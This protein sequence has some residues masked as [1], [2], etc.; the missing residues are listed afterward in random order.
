MLNVWTPG[1]GD[2]AV[3]S[4]PGMAARRWD[5]RRVGVVAAVRLHEPGAQQ[6]CRRRRYQP[7]PRRPRVP[8]RVASRRRVRRLGQRRHARHRRRARVGARQHRPLRRR[9]G[10]RDDLR[11]VRRRQQDH[12]PARHAVCAGTVPQRVRDEW[13]DARRADPRSGTGDERPH[14]RTPRGRH[15]RRDIAQ[16]RRRSV[17]AGIARSLRWGRRPLRRRSHHQSQ[18]SSPSRGRGARGIRQ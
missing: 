7:S 16:A 10:K 8:R 6:R 14:T 1:A 13:S 9:P 4:R 11:R 17:R 3:A 15:R 2:G 5:E 18:P 12:L